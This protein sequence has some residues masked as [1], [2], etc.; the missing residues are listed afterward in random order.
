MR[1][2]MFPLFSSISNFLK[3]LIVG[4]RREPLI[5]TL[6]PSCS[7]SSLLFCV[8]KIKKW[9]F[10]PGCLFT[11]L[12]ALSRLSSVLKRRKW[13][14][15]SFH[16]CNVRQV[17]HCIKPLLPNDAEQALNK[18][19]TISL[20]P[21]LPLC[22]EAFSF[23]AAHSP[24]TFPRE[25]WRYLCVV[26]VVVVRCEAWCLPGPTLIYSTCKRIAWH[27]T[28]PT[29]CLL[30]PAHQQHTGVSPCSVHA[31]LCSSLWPLNMR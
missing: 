16:V 27:G 7:S 12:P 21:P 31:L 25:K 15:G 26:R 1:V 19:I 20:S 18:P 8:T 11:L 14:A 24:Q 22:S 13:E 3:F 23:W 29:R 5:R 10:Y 2:E 4:L 28:M 17:G 30:Q 6:P 9:F